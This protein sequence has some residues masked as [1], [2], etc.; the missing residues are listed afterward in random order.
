[1]KQKK[2]WIIGLL[3][4]IGLFSQAQQATTTAGGNATGIGGNVAYSLGQIGYTTS[5]NTSGSVAEGVQQPFEIFIV[6]GI[7]NPLYDL[8]VAVYP[9]P[10]ND[11][12]QLKIENSTLENLDFQL[13]DLSGKLILSRKIINTIENIDLVNLPCN[14]YFLKV[15]KNN[16]EVKTYK[17]IKN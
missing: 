13:L 14:S 17:I 8:S 6:L 11:F 2:I 3:L 12:L 10:S 9:N 15:T 4:S 1:M 7:D 5:I 16:I